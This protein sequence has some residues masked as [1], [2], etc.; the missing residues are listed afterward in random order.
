MPD[1]TAIAIVSISATALVGIGAPAVTH[2]FT[3]RRDAA[4]RQ[5]DLDKQCRELEAAREL[6]DVEELRLLL[7]SM[8][9]NIARALERYYEVHGY[10]RQLLAHAGSFESGATRAFQAAGRQVAVDTTRLAIRLGS[11]HE[12]RN[13]PKAFAE[14]ILD[15]TH[16]VRRAEQRRRDELGHDRELWDAV[17]DGGHALEDARDKFTAEAAC[18]VRSRIAQ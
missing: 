8:V 14:A 5:H 12:L 10:F 2:L 7:D 18:L 4:T 13:A 17:M 15:V 9:Q 6:A 11:E 1:S 3:S 16:N